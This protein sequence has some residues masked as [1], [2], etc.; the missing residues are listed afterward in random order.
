MARDLS[1]LDA[2]QS[3]LSHERARLSA[4]RT[5]RELEMRAVWVAGIERELA[6]EMDFLSGSK[7]PSLDM[8]DDELLAALG[9]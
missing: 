4:A 6:D 2:I 1:H 9:E 7:A 5:P 3:R 8:T